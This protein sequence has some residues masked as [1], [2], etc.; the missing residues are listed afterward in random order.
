MK[1]LQLL[2]AATGCSELFLALR[3]F[4]REVLYTDLG[5]TELA[6]SSLG[7]FGQLLTLLLR[8]PDSLLE[9]DVHFALG[10]VQRLLVHQVE[11]KKADFLRIGFSEATQSVLKIVGTVFRLVASKVEPLAELVALLAKSEQ[12]SDRIGRGREGE[13]HAAGTER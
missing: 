4:E 9:L 7:R 10:L 6:A 11:L 12:K 3:E 2:L 13:R 8:V 1:L 5:F